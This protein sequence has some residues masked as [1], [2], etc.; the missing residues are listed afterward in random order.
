MPPLYKR[1]RLLR[2]VAVM[3]LTGGAVAVMLAHQIR[4]LPAAPIRSLA[5]WVAL[6]YA[7]LGLLFFIANRFGMMIV[8]MGCA[9]AIC[10]YF[11]ELAC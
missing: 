8:C 2:L 1:K 7:A 9:A 6:G 3:L 10:F 4:Q 5:E 11:V